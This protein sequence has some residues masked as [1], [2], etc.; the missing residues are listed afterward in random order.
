MGASRAVWRSSGAHVDETTPYSQF[1][2]RTEERIRAAIGSAAFDRAFARGAAYSFEQAVALA[3][4][5]E[6]ERDGVAKSGMAGRLTPRE[7]EIA[8]LIGEGLSNREIAVR[9]V[10][11]QRTAE[12]HVEHILTKLGFAS[13]AQVASWVTE[14][15]DR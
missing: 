15:P 11:S 13:R 10:I 8:V 12:T 4:G 6:A 9:L 14:H 1:D 5:E 2:D 3:L 7:H